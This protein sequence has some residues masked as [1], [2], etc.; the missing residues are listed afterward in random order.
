VG[1]S[2]KYNPAR[3][4]FATTGINWLTSDIRTLLVNIQYVPDPS[5]SFVSDIPPSGIAVR[6]EVLASKTVEDGFVRAATTRYEDLLL[7]Q[8]VTGLVLYVD[9][10]VDATSRLLAFMDDELAF[11]FTPAGFHYDFSYDAAKGGFFRE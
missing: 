9:T 3:T 11:P 2:F 1:V 4:L 10:G 8:E 5:H 7:A 6:G